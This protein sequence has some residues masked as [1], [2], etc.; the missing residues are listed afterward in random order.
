[1]KNI[2]FLTLLCVCLGSMPLWALQG[3]DGQ[4]QENPKLAAAATNLSALQTE[5]SAVAKAAPR[6]AVSRPEPFILDAEA[7]KTLQSTA[8]ERAEDKES[9]LEHAARAVELKIE[10][11]G[12]LNVPNDLMAPFANVRSLSIKHVTL[13]DLP[14]LPCPEKLESLALT[15]S[16]FQA[17]QNIAHYR[18]LRTLHIFG[19]MVSEVICSLPNLE[20]LKLSFCRL[21]DAQFEPLLQLSQTLRQL[22]LNN[23][24]SG[25]SAEMRQRLRAA[26]GDKVSFSRGPQGIV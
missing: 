8:P 15:L 17:I 12:H 16:I 1:M 10:G 22:H 25:F 2:A 18:N 6:K 23:S 5:T 3:E 20:E 7:L 13:D 4:T 14:L 9:L 26:F 24:E 19:S 11:D 21:T